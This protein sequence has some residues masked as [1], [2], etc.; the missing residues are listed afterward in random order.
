MA[1]FTVSTKIKLTPKGKTY[2]PKGSNVH[3][4]QV[5]W[6]VIKAAL[7]NGKTRTY[8]SLC[9]LTV[10]AFNKANHAPYIRYAVKS[11]WLKVIV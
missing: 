9:G 5:N 10:P 3:Q 6:G 8:G 2:T 7:A 1:N 4:H 11:G